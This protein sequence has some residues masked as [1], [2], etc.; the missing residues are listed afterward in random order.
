M[1]RT[2]EH[3]EFL[4]TQTSRDLIGERNNE[5]KEYGKSRGEVSRK[6]EKVVNRNNFAWNR[7][8]EWEK[9]QSN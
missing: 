5:K 6:K 2:K 8:Q 7:E 3:Y 9:I 4:N 1:V